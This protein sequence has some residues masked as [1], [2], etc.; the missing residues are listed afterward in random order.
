MKA[1]TECKTRS[2][3]WIPLA[4]AVALLALGWDCSAQS[5]ATYH[6]EADQAIESYLIKFWNGGRQYL[7]NRVPDD[8]SLTGYWTYANGWQA[9]MD[10]VERT[11]KQRYLGLIESFYLGQNAQGWGSAYYD[12]ECWMVMAL[13]RAYDLTANRNYLAEAEAIFA[14]VEKA[15][16][17]SCC[18]G[19]HGGMWWDKAHT[20]KATAANAGGALSAAMLYRRTT[21]APYLNFAKQVY[22]YWQSHMVNPTSYQV[23]DHLQPDGTKIWWKFTYNEGL[24]IGASLE[25]NEATGDAS[26][27]TN[28]HHIASFMVADEV[29]PTRFGNVLYDGADSGCTGD[30]AQFKAPA[31]R[32]LM[33]LYA[34]DTTKIQYYRVLKASADA[35]WNLARDTNSNLFAS[36]WAG[37]EESTAEQGQDNAA[38]AAI[39]LFAELAGAYPGTGASS[40]QYEAEDATI[41]NLSLEATYGS[42]TGWGYL[43]SWGSDGQSVDFNINVP[44]ATSYTFTLRY[45]AGAGT[46]SRLISINGVNVFPNQSFPGTGS[47]S[48]YNTV[49]LTHALRA[50][51]NTI[52]IVYSSTFGSRNFLN[53]DNLTLIP[54]TPGP[55]SIAIQGQNA[56]ISWSG[57]GILQSAQA[58]TGPWA[59]VAG[60]PASPYTVGPTG[61]ASPD[62]GRFYRLRD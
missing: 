58:I 27:L 18:G 54:P 20:Q 61:I 62:G 29:V 12:D 2:Y 51:P 28:A 60:N 30:C 46:A 19:A 35:V 8:G 24:T 16:D 36:N 21:S 3:P 15:W 40:N 6:D 48:S 49:A 42:F 44:S 53:L 23:A 10:G 47:W 5:V 26:Y 11:G 25:L 50:G 33:R 55:I 45:A 56:V 31:F 9:L 38:C 22:S 37:P 52:S 41:H 59:D 4:A 57:A 39:N 17:T 32:N 34:K 43:A 14:D 1:T 13:L 7:R